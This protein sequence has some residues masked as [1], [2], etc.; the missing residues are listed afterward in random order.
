MLPA[1]ARGRPGAGDLCS[2]A[3][4][5][6]AARCGAS[7]DAG[8][9][10]RAHQRARLA[11][12]R[13]TAHA[14]RPDRRRLRPCCRRGQ[15]ACAALA[16]A[17]A[18]R[19]S[20]PAGS[21]GPMGSHISSSDAPARTAPFSLR[22]ISRRSASTAQ[23]RQRRGRWVVTV[24]SGAAVGA[25]LSSI[26]A[27]A[28]RLAFEVGAGHPRGSQ[29]GQ[30]QAECGDSEPASHR[31]CRRPA[32]RVDCRPRGRPGPLAGAASRSPRGSRA[33][34]SPSRRRPGA[35]RGAG[36]LQPPGDGR[37]PASAGRRGGRGR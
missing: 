22:L 1:I 10:R 36:R 7:G 29:R 12:R 9:P 6:D 11:C 34:R 31:G 17:C 28:G 20:A 5:N 33:P 37:P 32:D 25:A 19:S 16:A 13:G 24:R 18:E 15:R 26:G 27:Q 4:R 30:P 14:V 23:I 8:A 35:A 2:R 3:D 21:S